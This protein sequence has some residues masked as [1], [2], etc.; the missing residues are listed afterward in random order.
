MGLKELKFDL[1]EVLTGVRLQ[2]IYKISN[3]HSLKLH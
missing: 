2:V 3:D 1:V